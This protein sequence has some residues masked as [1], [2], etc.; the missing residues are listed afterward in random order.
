MIEVTWDEHEHSSKHV[1]VIISVF[2]AKW[3]L[4][5]LQTES[6]SH[7]KYYSV[8]GQQQVNQLSSSV[9]RKTWFIIY[10]INI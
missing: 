7:V 9:D 10:S 8:K 1:C 3:F 4:I 6:E 5:A 2:D